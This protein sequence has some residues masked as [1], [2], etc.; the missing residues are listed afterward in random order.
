MAVE[1]FKDDAFVG[2]DDQ[3]SF[4]VQALL[5]GSFSHFLVVLL[6]CH[7]LLHNS[8]F[9]FAL[10][11]GEFLLV[12]LEQ[13]RFGFQHLHNLAF[14]FLLVLNLSS[15]FGEGVHSNNNNGGIGLGDDDN[16]NET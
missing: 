13:L 3:S 15:I 5:D 1:Q 9:L 12:L 4:L 10:H 2:F 6:R 14:L 16:T 8:A 7:G 11:F